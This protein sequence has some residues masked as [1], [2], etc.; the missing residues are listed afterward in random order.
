MFM[1]SENQLQAQRWRIASDPTNYLYD[2]ASIV[3]ELDNSGNL[4]ARY[5]ATTDIDEPLSELRGTAESY[6]QL[7]GLGSV[8]SLSSS[9]GTVANTYSYDGYGNLAASTGST[10]NPFRYTGREFDQETGLYFY[11]ARYYDSN[12]GL[13]ISEDRARFWAGVN[14][15]RY[16][17]NNPANEVDPF[18]LNQPDKGDLIRRVVCNKECA[19]YL[20]GL[21]NVLKAIFE[22]NY[23][24]VSDPRAIV[25]PDIRKQ[26]NNNRMLAAFTSGHTTYY[27]PP[28]QDYLILDSIVFLHELRHVEGHNSEID[29]DYEQ[30]YSTIEKLC[31]ESDV[32]TTTVD[33]P[34]T[35]ECR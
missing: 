21:N 13:F 25:P 27:T 32:P 28:P 26:F 10:A 9:T 35:I 24:D 20:G 30:E 29:R 4:L 19:D 23:V 5:A 34:G 3:E 18:G 22:T 33:V 16:V 7:D 6:Y 1:S 8:T 12:L 17:N 31:P 15:Y 14:F 2:G 11:R